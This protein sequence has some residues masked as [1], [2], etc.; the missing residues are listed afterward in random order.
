MKYR[1]AM[2]C[3]GGTLIAGVYEAKTAAGATSK[4][5]AEH[6]DEWTYYLWETLEDTQKIKQSM[7]TKTTK[8]KNKTWLRNPDQRKSPKTFSVKMQRNK[9]GS[10]VLI[11]ETL[12]Q[13]KKNQHSSVWENVNTRD[14]AEE[15]RGSTIL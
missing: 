15:L 7:K 4:A 8:M 2:T 13:I 5:R 1:I 11:D 14:F 6:G 10:F 12:V 3:S 9:D